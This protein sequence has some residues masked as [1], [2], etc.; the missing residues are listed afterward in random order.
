V[1]LAALGMPWP[2][3]YPFDREY[4]QLA[5]IAGLIIGVCAP[6][7]GAFLVQ[8][9]LALVGD[10]IGH[11]AL[12]GVGI[13]LWL[14]VTPL[15]VALGAAM[16]A[17]LAIE[18]LRTRGHTRS[19]IALAVFFY[20]GIAAGVVFASRAGSTANL[21]PYLFGSIL[22]VA[23]NDLWTILGIGVVIIATIAI[24]GRALLATV[25]DPESSRVAGLP[26][27]G[28]NAMLAVLTAA[29]IVMAM[30]VVGVLLIAALMVLPVAISRIYAKS[31]RTTMLAAAAIGG[32]AALA[33]LAIARIAGLAAGGTIVLLV[34]VVFLLASVGSA[35][36]R[37]S[38]PKPEHDHVH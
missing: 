7:I 37:P 24:A 4:M 14:G 8:K 6:L 13:G 10:G 1:I 38:A 34:T 12:A 18:W 28:L 33:G 11:V 3:P 22:T 25:I 29:T 36:R 35:L 31:F 15:W 27:D 26:V 5:L 9:D 32:G 23:P 30:R 19:D 2:L 17:A 21:L 16:I 20:G